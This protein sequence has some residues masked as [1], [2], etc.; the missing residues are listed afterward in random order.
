MMPEQPVAGVEDD[1]R[2]E[3]AL[4]DPGHDAR[5]TPASG[6]TTGRRSPACMTS[7]T[8]RVSRRPSAPGGVVEGEPL[9]RETPHLVERDGQRVAQ[10]QGQRR[11]RGRG[12]VER[13]G[14]A[15]LH[16]RRA[17]RRP[18]GPASS[19]ACPRWRSCAPRRFRRYGRI[20]RSSSVSPLLL[21]AMTTS[22]PADGAEAAVERVDGV[23]EDRR[24]SRARQ[25]G[26][27]LLGDDA[28]GA[29]ADEDRLAPAAREQGDSLLEGGFIEAFGGVEQR[30]G[31]DPED[32]GRQTA[33]DWFRQ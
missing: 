27:D 33:G 18:P 21:T 15:R 26:G 25:G 7:A 13:A 3:A 2:A 30:P 23:K 31:L 10:G 12:Q 17:P 29:G 20:A 4:A 8:R 28:R 5:A 16:R 19:R 22:S 1:D 11:A 9:R 24:G 14:L 32:I 6:A